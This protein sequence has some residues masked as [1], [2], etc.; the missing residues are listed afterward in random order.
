[1][2][3]S[4]G[5]RNA[6]FSL[7]EMVIAMTIMLILLGIT[8]TLFSRVL[9]IRSRESRRTDALTSAQAALN[10]MSREI[11]NSG[12]GLYL[13]AVTKQPLNGIITADSGA[14]KI[15]F[16]AN[17][18]NSDL[19]ISS[20]GEDVTYFLDSATSSIVRYDPNDTVKPTSVVINRIS[21]VTFKYFNYTGSTST[22][23]ETT[24]PTGDTAR[25]RITIVVQ[26]DH[27]DGQPD[28]Q[29]VTFTSDVTLRNSDYMLNQY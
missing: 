21:T 15:H 22:P 13:D 23:T 16:K 28:G 26:L 25:V 3:K 12:F 6:G 7:V 19:T 8:A 11:S 20:P 17:V 18:V 4:V 29:T 1:M 27:V 5:N 24:T 14:N 2:K 10:V 9:G